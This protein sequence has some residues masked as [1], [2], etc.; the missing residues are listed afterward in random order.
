M[1]KT[2]F[3][4]VLVMLLISSQAFAAQFM[5]Y[6]LKDG[7]FESSATYSIDVYA[8]TEAPGD[9]QFALG[10]TFVT[11]TY[12][13]AVLS[14]PLLSDADA[15]LQSSYSVGLDPAG[16][17]DGFIQLQISPAGTPDFMITASEV[18]LARISFAI[19]P[20]AACAGETATIAWDDNA[21]HHKSGTAF[22]YF[23]GSDD[24]ALASA[25]TIGGTPTVS[26]AA[27]NSYSFTPTVVDGCG[28]LAFTIVNPPSWAVFDS[29]TGELN[30][31]PVL[32]DVGI[33]S[34]VAIRVTDQNGSWDEMTPFDIEVT[35]G[36]AAP[37]ISGTPAALV[38]AGSTYS[39]TPT[40]S[41]GCGVLTYSVV[42]LPSWASFD[43]ATG[44]LSGTPAASDAA[45]YT[46]IEITVTDELLAASTLAAFDI[47]VSDAGSSSSGGT[48]GGGG[49]CFISAL[50]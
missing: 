43:P 19:D 18:W 33:T 38:T 13:T 27:G 30:G 42:N 1:K 40:V 11:L 49:G 41:N 47:Q 25:P 32:A 23:S 44:E 28:T 36:C 20:T 15:A 37:V 21:I 48:G 3:M 10:E 5:T 8:N 4:I 34:D 16:L 7:G 35:A 39:F 6:T 14:A 50:R 2:L 22:L 26:I 17:G 24:S 12:N 9:S 31:S 29:G 46:G 45:D